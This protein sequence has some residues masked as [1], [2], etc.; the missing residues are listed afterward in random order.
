MAFILRL[1]R[2]WCGGWPAGWLSAVSLTLEIVLLGQRVVLT[3]AATLSR[4]KR[5]IS[6]GS[7]EGL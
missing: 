7:R 5:V 1:I 3:C 6:A 4:A 2:G